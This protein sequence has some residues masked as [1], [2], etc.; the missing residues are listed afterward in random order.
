[1]AKE[2]TSYRFDNE[3][4]FKLEELTNYYKKKDKKTNKSKVLS[5]IIADAYD[6]IN[7]IQKNDFSNNELEKTNREIIELEYTIIK[8][9]TTNLKEVDDIEEIK[10]IINAKSRFQKY[11]EDK[12]GEK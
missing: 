11:V 4:L 8:L 2:I 6:N 12:L 10:R 3:T 1:M 7:S 9:L 5:S